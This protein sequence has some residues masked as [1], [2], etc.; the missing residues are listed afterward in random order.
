MILIKSNYLFCRNPTPNL[1]N[2][3]TVTWE[4][5]NAQGNYLE[6]NENLKM[7]KEPYK[8]RLSLWAEIY[9]EALGNFI[10]LFC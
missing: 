10:K 4:A 2:D 7:G 5:S 1:D 9:S 8:D 3:V 6:I